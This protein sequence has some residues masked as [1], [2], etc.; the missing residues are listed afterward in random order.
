M[1]AVFLAD[2]HL[3][4]AEDEGYRDL[5]HFLDHLSKIDS[6][7][8]AGD[9]FDFWF[10]KDGRVYPEFTA[11]IEKLVH[12]KQ[13]GVHIVF[14]E[15]NHDFFMKSFFSDKL[16]MTV[17]AEWARIDLDGRAILISHGD[18]VDK[19]NKKY[20]FIRKILRSSHFYRVQRIMPLPVLWKMARLSSMASKELSE[21]SENLI[22]A[23]MEMFSQEK[24]QEGFDAVI[25][26][27][28]HKPLIKESVIGGRKR[29]FATLG[30]WV[31]HH[32]YLYYEDGL[33]TLRYLSDCAAS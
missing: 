30:D 8:I 5:M 19:T 16:G 1:R 26:G 18:T 20:L 2:A 9:F 10:C 12:L 23:K 28:C 15:G 13:S 21:E 27:H 31:K 22:A 17:Y 29:T 3:K 32:S 7:F 11:I 25:L 24:F 4:H 6:L 14:C 33:F